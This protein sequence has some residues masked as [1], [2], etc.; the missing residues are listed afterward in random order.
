MRSRRSSSSLLLGLAFATLASG[1]LL[2]Y[3]RHEHRVQFRAMQDLISERDQ[4]EVEW[5]ALQLE[6]ATWAGYRRIDRE[7]SERLAMRRPEMR[8]IVFLRVES[9]DSGLRSPGTESR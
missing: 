9:A 1:I 8:D 5:G 6:R 3:A 4:L 7:A 2:T